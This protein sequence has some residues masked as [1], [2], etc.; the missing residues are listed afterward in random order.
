MKQGMI[1]LSF[2]IPGEEHCRLKTRYVRTLKSM[3]DCA[4]E[5]I[6]G[7]IEKMEKL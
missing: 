4:R 3:K 5:M 6:Q 7:V 1:R 2:D